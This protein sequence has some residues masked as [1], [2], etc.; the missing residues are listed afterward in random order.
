MYLE[1]QLGGRPPVRTRHRDPAVP[2]TRWPQPGQRF[3][4]DVLRGNPRRHLRIR[5]DLVDQG[6]TGAAE[7]GGPSKAPVWEEEHEPIVFSPTPPRP[8]RPQSAPPPP[9][10]PSVDTPTP[11]AE[12]AV[13]VHETFTDDIE[14]LSSAK[15][16]EASPRA[17]PPPSPTRR[18]GVDNG[19][20]P[21]GIDPADFEEPRLTTAP[22]PAATGGPGFEALTLSEFDPAEIDIRDFT[23]EP[24]AVTVSP[25]DDEEPR[26]AAPTAAAEAPAAIPLPRDPTSGARGGTGISAIRPVADLRRSVRFYRDALGFRVADEDST[27][28]VVEH[29]RNRVVLTHAGDTTPPASGEISVDV[30]DIDASC[31]AAQVH[32]GKVVEPP[33]GTSGVGARRARLLDPDGHVLELVESRQR[34]D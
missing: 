5:W 22:P 8:R 21:D 12:T 17:T 9:K 15:A 11:T 10:A 7:A 30:T 19:H 18:P 14:E 20:D 3:P 16:P 31:A 24:P 28:A 23:G 4:V 1:V 6:L 34:E 2:L 29:E 32:E 13:F 25:A 27:R 33:A 26:A